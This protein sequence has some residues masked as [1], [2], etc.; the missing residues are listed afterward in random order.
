[1]SCGGNTEVGG[2]RKAGTRLDL[3][4]FCKKVLQIPRCAESGVAH[5]KLGR[6]F[7]R[8]NIRFAEKWR[9]RIRHMGC[10]KP[11]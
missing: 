7:R 2:G 8:I 4:R 6:E 11:L 5:L 10:N 3:R 9:C 1:L